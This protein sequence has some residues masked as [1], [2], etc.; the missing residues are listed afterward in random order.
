MKG[1]KKVFVILVLLVLILSHVNFVDSVEYGLDYDGNGNLIKDDKFEYEYNVF[2]N[3]V[4]IRD[5]RNIIA[6]YFYDYNGERIK[7]VENEKITYYVGDFLREVNGNDKEDTI[8]YYHNGQLI[9]KEGDE[10]NYYYP[11]HLGSTNLI[12]DEDGNVEKEMNY[13]PFGESL[14]DNDEKYTFTGQEYDDE[15]GLMYYGARYYSPDLRRAP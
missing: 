4:K 12:T 5:G 6:E 14:V 3:L 8:Y 11:D 15:T 13:L 7:K 2:N 9:A 1:F 10:K